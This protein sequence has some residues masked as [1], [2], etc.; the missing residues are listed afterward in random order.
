MQ[1]FAAIDYAE[2]HD[3]TVGVIVHRDGEW[4][5]VDRMDVAVPQPDV[6][7]PVQW[8]EDW[9]RQS[10]TACPQIQFVLAEYKLLC[11]IKRSQTHREIAP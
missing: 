6:P 10:A 3:R 5:V 9:I 4:I 2:K 7:V 1:Y 11:S 8:V